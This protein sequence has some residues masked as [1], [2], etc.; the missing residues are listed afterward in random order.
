MTNDTDIIALR[1]PKPVDDPLTEIARDGTCWMLAAVLGAEADTCVAQHG[2]DVLPDRRQRGVRH[3]HWPERPIQT[4]I[5]ALDARRRT[6]RDR[7]AGRA[8]L[9]SWPR[10]HRKPPCSAAG[11]IR[12]CDCGSGRSAIAAA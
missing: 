9:P 10:S 5:G 12:S 2:E 4:G 7:A 3:G 1:Q 6:V 8:T 11:S